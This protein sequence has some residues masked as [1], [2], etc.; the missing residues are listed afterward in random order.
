[1]CGF[2][3]HVIVLPSEMNYMLCTYVFDSNKYVARPY[4]H[5]IIAR[6]NGKI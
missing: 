5:V 1:M 4:V 6:I 3:E 2:C